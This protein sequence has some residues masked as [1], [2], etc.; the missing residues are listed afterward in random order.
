MKLRIVF[1]ASLIT[2]IAALP[3][4]ASAWWWQDDRTTIIDVALEV[5][6]NVVPGA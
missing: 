6:E 1:I 3:L 2:L 4:S 5:N